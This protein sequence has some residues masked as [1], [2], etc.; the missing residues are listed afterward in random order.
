MRTLR[1]GEFHGA[2]RETRRIAV[3]SDF[4]EESE[5]VER[6]FRELVVEGHEVHAVHVVAEEELAPARIGVLAVDPED[7]DIQRPLTEAA[8][9][10]YRAAYDAWREDLANAF[11]LAGVAYV[12]VVTSEAPAH[13]VRRIVAGVS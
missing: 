8:Q 5:E 7:H 9:P 2:R 4:L 13:A 10:G 6:R 12:E 3:I 1:R 11:R